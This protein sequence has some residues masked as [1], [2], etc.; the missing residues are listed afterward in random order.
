[1]T[2]VEQ[3]A[4]IRRVN[5]VIDH[6]TSQPAG[7]LS[8]KRL[9]DLAG[10]SEFHF[11]RIFKGIMGETLSQFVWRVR[12]ERGAALLRA[13]PELTIAQAA[14]ACGFGSTAAYSR[15]FKTRY[16]CAPSSWDRQ[17]RLHSESSGRSANFPAYHLSKLASVETHFKVHFQ[18]LSTQRLAYIRVQDAYA[19]FDRIQTA[20]TK[21]LRWYER[22]GGRLSDTILY[23]MSQDDPDI[24][25]QAQCRFDWCLRV[26]D[27]WQG[28]GEVSMRTFPS[29]LLAVI[30]LDGDI[31]MED[32]IWQYFWRDW[33][34]RSPYQP[35]DLPAMEIYRRWPHLDGGWERFTLDCA[36]PI[37]RL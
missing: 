6:I 27:N 19:D 2:T 21:L 18:H 31:H 8:L 12:V 37:T 23:G 11:H 14:Q 29:T 35:R 34:P 4:Y 16:G 13:D 17:R 1:M 22:Q 32:H 5:L 33:L 24:T 28:E 15:A 36:V 20:Y 26:P 9:A 3:N 30:P 7:D 25:P 10:F